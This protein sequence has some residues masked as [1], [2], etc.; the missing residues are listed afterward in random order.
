MFCLLGFLSPP[1]FILVLFT[2]PQAKHHTFLPCSLLFTL[3]WHSPSPPPSSA[4]MSSAVLFPFLS[5]L[6]VLSKS[7]S[8]F[9]WQISLPAIISLSSPLVSPCSSSP[10]LR[11]FISSSSPPCH[12]CCPLPWLPPSSSPPYCSIPPP[13]SFP[14]SVVIKQC[15]H[16]PDII[17]KSPPV[18][19]QSLYMYCLI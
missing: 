17:C 14:L 19:W 7:S 6:F 10:L 4:R 15:P 16:S 18:G 1:L 5:H 2:C 12:R 13:S 3:S 8:L 9:F 11:T